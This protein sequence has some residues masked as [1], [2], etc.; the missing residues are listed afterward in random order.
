MYIRHGVRVMLILVLSVAGWLWGNGGPAAMACMSPALA[1]N[2]GLLIQGLIEDVSQAQL[3][4]TIRDL[5]DDDAI[6]GWD[7]LASRY[8][9][10]P[11]L[12]HK[13]EYIRRRMEQAGLAVRDQAFRLEDTTQVNLEGTL[14]GWGPGEDLVYILCAH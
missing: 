8:S 14:P 4:D 1:R 7:A 9:L 6:P 12:G 2:H 13:R 10:A 3:Y 11:G 5:Q